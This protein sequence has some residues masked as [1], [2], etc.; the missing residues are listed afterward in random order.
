MQEQKWHELWHKQNLKDFMRGTVSRGLPESCRVRH[1][2]DVWQEVESAFGEALCRQEVDN[3][4]GLL[5][6]IARR[7]VASHRRTCG[8][9][10][11][12]FEHDF[13]KPYADGGDSTQASVDRLLE[14]V[15]A[16][17][18]ALYEDD[19][20]TLVTLLKFLLHKCDKLRQVAT[21]TPA[22]N[23][24]LEDL[25]GRLQGL[26]RNPDL[27]TLEGKCPRDIA[28]DLGVDL[29]TVYRI[30]A[31]AKVRVRGKVWE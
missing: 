21:V 6:V 9:N 18:R 26:V 30:V 24:F 17:L 15:I 23:A 12:G 3:P 27:A 5:M 16:E 19:P 25:E 29:A 8:R 13:E 11:Y 20:R 4:R 22:E 2:E 28:G 1:Q 31:A 10:V 7:R 14:K